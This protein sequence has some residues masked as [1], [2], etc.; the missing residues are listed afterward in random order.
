MSGQ[1]KESFE[2]VWYPKHDVIGVFTE[3]D[4]LLYSWSKS[5]NQVWNIITNAEEK[6]CE[7][8]SD[9]KVVMEYIEALLSRGILKESQYS[10]NMED[11]KYFLEM[12]YSEDS[13]EFIDEPEWEDSMLW[14]PSQCYCRFLDTT[15]RTIYCIYLRWR[16]SDPW[17]SELIKCDPMGELL[18]RRDWPSIPTSKDYSEDEY[19]ELKEECIRTIKLMYPEL[20]WIRLK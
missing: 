19:P 3:D 2:I 17:T 10:L 9:R 8:V 15:E 13:I 6:S 12:W 7:S 18:Y 20:R 16:H 4:T 1:R 5:Q 14:C 11:G